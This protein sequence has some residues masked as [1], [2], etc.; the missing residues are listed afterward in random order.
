MSYAYTREEGIQFMIL[1]SPIYLHGD[2]LPI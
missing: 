2:N 1:P